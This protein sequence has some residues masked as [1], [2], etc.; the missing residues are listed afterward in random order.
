[1]RSTTQRLF[2]VSVL[3]LVVSILSALISIIAGW[4]AQFGGPGDPNNVAGEFLTRGT[5]TAA[6]LFP[7][8]VLLVVFILLVPSRR[9]WGTLAAVGLCLLAVLIF[10]GRWGKH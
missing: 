4:P 7:I 1:M 6:P 5:A 9:W 10:I 2:S 3:I 8:L